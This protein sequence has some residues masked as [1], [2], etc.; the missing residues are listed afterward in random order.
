MEFSN[1]LL[2]ILPFLN[3]SEWGGN[4]STNPKVAVPTDDGKSVPQPPKIR[5][6][7]TQETHCLYNSGFLFLEGDYTIFRPNPKAQFSFRSSSNSDA[8]RAID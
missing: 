3:K 6:L 1:R 5:W 7:R 4:L 2:G 8:S